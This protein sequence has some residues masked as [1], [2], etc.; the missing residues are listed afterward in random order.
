MVTARRAPRRNLS[1]KLGRLRRVPKTDLSA[2]LLG[3]LSSKRLAAER[4]TAGALMLALLLAACGGPT[5]SNSLPTLPPTPPPTLTPLP[6]PSPT[7]FVPPT[8]TPMPTPVP[9][10]VTPLPALSLQITAQLD[11][12]TP[13]AGEEFVVALSVTNDGD[14]AAR[15]VYIATGGPWDRWTVLGIEPSGTF[16]PDAAGWHIVTDEQVPAGETRTILVHTRADE[17]SQE[18]LTFAVREAEPRELAQ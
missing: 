9:P 7:L 16:V 5:Q 1:Q 13:H 11:P 14:R 4:L 15:G 17:P 18:K 8:L 12:P 3:G 6:S 2:E 10:T